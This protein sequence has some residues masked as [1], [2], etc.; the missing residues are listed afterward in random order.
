MYIEEPRERAYM[1]DYFLA[2]PIFF[3]LREVK[4]FSQFCALFAN[5]STG[6]LS[7]WKLN[8]R[9]FPFGRKLQYSMVAVT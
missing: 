6:A 2:Y 4:V 3:L 8:I 9:K 7:I 1:G 5:V